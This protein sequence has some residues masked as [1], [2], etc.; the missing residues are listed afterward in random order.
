MQV[1]LNVAAQRFFNTEQCAKRYGCSPRHWRR[2]VD[3]GLA[4]RPVRFQR[5]VRWPIAELEKWEESGCPA[6]ERRANRCAK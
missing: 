2:M 5:L 1:D 6:I 3:S 4:P